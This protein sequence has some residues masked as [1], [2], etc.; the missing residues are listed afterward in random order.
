MLWL[1]NVLLLEHA[2]YSLDYEWFHRQSFSFSLYFIMSRHQWDTSFWWTKPIRKGLSGWG[3][4]KLF[5]LLLLQKLN[6]IRK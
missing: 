4:G 1:E 5:L 3:K 6:L 2:L